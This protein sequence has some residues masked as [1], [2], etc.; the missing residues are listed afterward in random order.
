MQALRQ[1]YLLLLISS[2]ASNF[3]L[4][5]KDCVC[6]RP[7]LVPVAPLA[8]SSPQGGA[9]AIMLLMAA[10]KACP[11]IRARVGGRSRFRAGQ[12]TRYRLGVETQTTQ[13]D[14]C[15]LAC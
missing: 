15:R 14:P 6:N 1:Y 4:M 12:S 2:K 8:G 11:L 13:V 5:Q 10:Q 7:A 3:V 9:A